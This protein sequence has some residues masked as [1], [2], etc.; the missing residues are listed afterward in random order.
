MG[1]PKPPEKAL[2]FIGSFFS[3]EDY[4]FQARHHLENRFGEIVMEGPA[5]MLNVSGNYWDELGYPIY[6]RFIFMR[7]LVEQDSLAAIKLSTNEIEGVL[8]RDGKRN[9][10]LDPGYLTTA[11]VVL[12][13]TK[14][15]S[16]R[17]YLRD[18]I[19]A[20][21][22]LLF[23]KGHYMPHIKTYRDYQDER[24]LRLFMIARGLLLSG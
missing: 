23:Q 24:Y 11:K 12:A 15:Y 17:I 2:L 3:N 7:D 20:E 6:R 16:H 9:I 5:L 4:Y 21:T 8:S 19:Y 13:S 1:V 10:N 22:T 14:D 18:G